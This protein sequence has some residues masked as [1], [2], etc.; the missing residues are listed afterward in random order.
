MQEEENENEELDAENQEGKLA[1]RG[2]RAEEA[3]YEAGDA[4]DTAAAAAASAQ[5]AAQAGDPVVST[6]T[7]LRCWPFPSL[8][9]KICHALY[10]PCVGGISR[11]FAFED[12]LEQVLPRIVVLAAPLRARSSEYSRSLCA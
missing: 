1:W 5:A 12:R 3:T 2:G 6:S 8:V 10:P 9:F 11:N 7:P 4:D